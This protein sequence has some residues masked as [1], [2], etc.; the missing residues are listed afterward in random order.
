MSRAPPFF[1]PQAPAGGSRSLLVYN[2][3][4]EV[5]VE[6][7]ML[8][9]AFGMKQ[10]PDTEVFQG[11]FKL[12]DMSEKNALYEL[13]DRRSLPVRRSPARRASAFDGNRRVKAIF[14]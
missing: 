11:K 6:H 10:L 4:K 8:D 3:L 9:A 13:V 7:L 5:G 14:R 12:M 1:K 2:L